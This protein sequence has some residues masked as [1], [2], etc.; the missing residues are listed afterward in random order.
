MQKKFTLLVLLLW[1]LSPFVLT[2]QV[3]LTVNDVSAECDDTAFCVNIEATNFDT[4]SSMQFDLQWDTAL[5]EFV[6]V[7]SALPA[8][9]LTNPANAA[10]GSLTFAWAHSVFPPG[11][12]LVD[13]SSVITLCF[14]PIG[15]VGTST[16]SFV[17][18]TNT[19]ILVTVGA[20]P[21]TALTLG[22]DLFLNSGTIT[23]NDSEF[24]T[25]DCPADITVDAGM[26]ISGLAPAS[27]GDNCNV[28]SVSYELTG[29]T[30][31]M[32]N[33]DASGT[34]FN[35]GMTTVTYTITDDGNNTETCSFNV[36]AQGGTP[37]VL[38][39]IPLVDFDCDNNTI[40]MYLTVN[41]FIDIGS[42]QFTTNWDETN[43][44]YTGHTNNIP[45]SATFNTTFVN[46]GILPLFWSDA[47]PPFD[48]LTLPDGDTLFSATFNLIGT[49]TPPVF[50][51]IDLPVLPIEIADNNSIPL[52]PSE[53]T[54]LPE[55]VNVIDNTDPN[56]DTCVSGITVPN[57]F[58]LCGTN[59]SWTPPTASDACDA[60]VDIT[61]SHSPGDFFLVGTTTVTYT[62]TDD[63]GNTATCTFDIT[64]ADT[65][66]PMLTCPADITVNAGSANSMVV[67]GLTPTVT[68]NCGISM[69]TFTQMGATNGNGSNDASG[70]YQVGTTTVTY[71][72]TGLNMDVATCSFMV[73][74][75]N[76]PLPTIT[77][78]A[79][80]T[81]STD[82]DQCTAV[83]NGIA[84]ITNLDAGAIASIDYT[85]SNATTGTGSNDAS[86]TAFN[87]GT[88]TVTY[89]LTDTAGVVIGCDFEI[90]VEDNQVPNMLCPSVDV[91][92]NQTDSCNVLVTNNIA[93][94]VTDNCGIASISYVLT[95]AMTGSGMNSA[96]GLTFP[97]GI[98][99]VNY[100]AID[101]N[102]NTN[103]C[104]VMVV[105]S[106][107]Q[108]PDVSCP[109]DTTFLA[110]GGGT[111]AVATGI[112]P[113]INENCG[114][115]DISHR[116]GI[117]GSLVTG[118]ASGTTF[119]MGMTEVTY[120][121][122]DLSGNVDSCTFIVT[123][124]GA[125]MGDLIQCPSDVMVNTDPNLCQATVN[126]IA[127]VTLVDPAAIQSIEYTIFNSMGTTMGSDDASGNVF[128][129]GI[130]TIRYIATDFANEMDSCIF[131]VTVND[132]MMPSWTNCPVDT[133][134][135]AT[136]VSDCRATVTWNE[137]TPNDNCSVINIDRTHMP[138][139]TFDLGNT[140]VIYTAFDPSGN[141]GTCA[142]VISVSD[143]EPPN[144]ICPDTF[145]YTN[146]GNCQ[147]I[148]D[149][150][151]P[152]AVDNCPGSTLTSTHSP[153]DTFTIG[154]T[155]SVI[156]FAIDAVGQTGQCT[157]EIMVPDTTAPVITNCLSDSIIVTEPGMCTA[158]YNWGDP[159]AFDECVLA[160]FTSSAD[161]G[162][163]FPV[164]VTTVSY[165]ATDA[166]GNSSECSFNVTVVD[167]QAPVVNCPAAIEVRLDGTVVSD[168]G[169][170]LTS[171]V[172]NG[173]CDSIALSFTAPLATDNCEGSLSSVFDLGIESGQTFPIGTTM[174][175]YIATDA[176]GN[177]DT[178]NFEI[179][180]VPLAPVVPSIIGGN[181]ACLGGDAQ[182]TVLE[183][184]GATY[185]W[186]GPNAWT[187][188][189]ATPIREGLTMD[190][191]GDYTVVCTT[192]DGCTSTGMV[193]LNLLPIP[194]I[195][196]G[197]NAPI[198][199]DGSNALELFAMEETGSISV[200]SWEWTGPAGFSAVDQNPIIPDADN[201]NSGIYTVIATGDNGCTVSMTVDV[202]IL[203]LLPPT[204]E[205]D[206]A[207][208][209]CLGQRC[210]LLGTQFI[211]TPD[212]H[213][214]EVSPAIT[215]G[216]PDD[217]NSNETFIEPTAPGIYIVNYWVSSNGCVSDT[218]TI[219]ITVEGEPSTVSDQSFVPYETTV[220]GI[221]VLWND[222]ISSMEDV[223]VFLESGVSN[224]SLDLGRDGVFSY[225]PDN[226]FLGEDQFSYQVC[227]NCD[228]TKC[229]IGV[230]TLTV[231]FDGEECEVP[232]VITPNGDG[233][234][235]ELFINCLHAEAF[236][237][238]T[239]QIYNEWGDRIFSASPYLNDW[240]G[241]YEG[242]P[243]PDGT[244]FYIFQSAANAE[245]Q[246]GYITLFR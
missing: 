208:E 100:T 97:V 210:F 24:P 14:N 188:T 150:V 12:T 191:A 47:S 90:L 127:P 181:D 3:T 37:S 86:G 21:G 1:C 121:V 236:P 185:D 182:F 11:L 10:N 69:I 199:T 131:T 157:F 44:T 207:A 31:G 66:I 147:A 171:A 175:R 79:D 169:G 94:V 195:T 243:L 124:V 190:D 216:L 123:V 109:N 16:I 244:Y 218:A 43:L 149:W 202:N 162:D 22:T 26:A 215:A 36:T 126:G 228:L 138:G 142:F 115:A 9:V 32:G 213:F 81:A 177:A 178:C 200:T 70:V 75:E 239:I 48:G 132:M 135:S 2:A 59:V 153:G 61:S 197:S 130:S 113:V 225:T 144:V 106:D 98:T 204:I 80:L 136:N 134:F 186:T 74:V 187:A 128:P 25:I 64:V 58:G 219:L 146:I 5:V 196:A 220:D 194:S 205:S 46:D 234:N 45:P 62:A 145:T 174:Q 176:S 156:Y 140:T 39:F 95:G 56:F 34:I 91:F 184:P 116:I 223:T 85:L 217:T 49:Y 201:D 167:D 209:A 203:E 28:N 232:T 192:A 7:S 27:F 163:A 154:T 152:T 227:S 179:R 89:I 141:S 168:P 40:T 8:T 143:Q 88:T 206:C 129:V 68:D 155:T 84:P 76:D 212:Q 120:I 78:P 99:N 42:M 63:A 52:D 114:I 87:Q 231:I 221:N 139:D 119:N 107:N 29:A 173:N 54:F 18:G 83:V 148:V 246:K 165:I 15:V 112:D 166:A 20:F 71:T 240:Q 151:P 242:D 211:P 33:D 4:V 96:T 17:D 245:V 35:A 57:D 51:F 92:D 235:D 93:P 237:N 118:S 125:P 73:T 105:V 214:W 189:G 122:E 82:P 53:Y 241:T 38:E 13:G 133:I 159:S 180:V 193:T 104:S 67:N 158:V 110:T 170:L 102:G 226:G 230:V 222:S 50:S 198:C 55:V 224:G 19:P 65:Q 137:P 60:M 101:V 233:K 30:T 164:G 117:G 229:A 160:S 77:C 108:T 41:N 111:T 23:I 183:T 103:Q 238:N 161:P 72:V 6:G 172:P